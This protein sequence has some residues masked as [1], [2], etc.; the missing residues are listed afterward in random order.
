MRRSARD[1]TTAPELCWRKDLSSDRKGDEEYERGLASQSFQFGPGAGANRQ[2][3]CD[4]VSTDMD[5]CH[6]LDTGL[7]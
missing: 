5:T 3:I 7:L 4:T 1:K 6:T 2:P